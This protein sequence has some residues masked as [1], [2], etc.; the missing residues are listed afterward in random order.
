MTDTTLCT[1]KDCPK[2]FCARKSKRFISTYQS[3]AFYDYT[4]ENCFVKEDWWRMTKKEDLQDNE[5]CLS[6]RKMGEHITKLILGIEVL[7]WAKNK[8]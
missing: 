4:K 6:S 2:I 5:G 1:N 3:Y 8:M 7:K